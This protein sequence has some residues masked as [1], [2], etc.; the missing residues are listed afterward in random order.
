METY[1]TRMK[2]TNLG[3][4]PNDDE[5]V[6]CSGGGGGGNAAPAFGKLNFVVMRAT[7]EVDPHSL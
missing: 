4:T 1:T 3:A 2:R 7:R 6:I 5:M